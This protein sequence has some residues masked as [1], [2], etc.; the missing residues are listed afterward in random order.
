MKTLILVTLDEETGRVLMRTRTLDGQLFTLEM[1]PDEAREIGSLLMQA[2]LSSLAGDHLFSM[3]ESEN[4]HRKKE[5]DECN[6][7]GGKLSSFRPPCRF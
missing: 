4:S 6:S 5:Q 2:C 1:T 7:V 3:P